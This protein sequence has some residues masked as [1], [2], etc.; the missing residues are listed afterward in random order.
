MTGRPDEDITD[1]TRAIELSGAPPEQMAKALNNRGFANNHAARHE[2]SLDDSLG[3][4]PFP[5]KL[6]RD[7]QL[8][9]LRDIELKG[10]AGFAGFE[11][12][13]GGNDGRGE[14]VPVGE[15]G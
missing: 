7:L 9:Q 11:V 2:A 14:A 6:T 8:K 12:S 13:V 3:S 4:S 5:H 1:C 15:V 10:D